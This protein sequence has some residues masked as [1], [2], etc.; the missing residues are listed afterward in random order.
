MREEIKMHG[1]SGR[2]LKIKKGNYPQCH[3]FHE[4]CADAVPG[5]ATFLLKVE[6]V[7]VSRAQR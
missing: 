4:C 1:C 3:D 2:R 6:I 5:N 7:S